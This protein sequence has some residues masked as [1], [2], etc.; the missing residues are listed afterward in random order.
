MQK[1]SLG[2]ALAKKKTPFQARVLAM[3]SRAQG[4]PLVLLPAKT[5]RVDTACPTAVPTSL[6]C[7]CCLPAEAQGA[8]GREEEGEHG[9]A[10]QN[11]HDALVVSRRRGGARQGEGGTGEAV[12]GT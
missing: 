1:T 2:F 11:K 6:V 3:I 9:V 12:A 8:R 10:G 7:A 4:L 5:R